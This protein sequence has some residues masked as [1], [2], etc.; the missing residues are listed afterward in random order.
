MAWPLPD[1]SI[2]LSENLFT[3]QGIVLPAGWTLTDGMLSTIDNSETLMMFD[4]PEPDYYLLEY[5]RL[6][7]NGIDCAIDVYTGDTVD[8]DNI[9]VDPSGPYGVWEKRRLMLYMKKF[10][11]RMRSGSAPLQLRNIRVHRAMFTP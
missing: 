1:S 5:E 3:W 10:R 2:V 4:T 7:A 6:T 11:V 8:A 9:T